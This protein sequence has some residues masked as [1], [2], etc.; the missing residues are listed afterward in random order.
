[1]WFLQLM[2]SEHI[3]NSITMAGNSAP[4][5]LKMLRCLRSPSSSLPLLKRACVTACKESRVQETS[6]LALAVHIHHTRFTMRSLTVGKQRTENTLGKLN[7]SQLNA[8]KYICL[9][10]DK[11]PSILLFILHT[12]TTEGWRHLSLSSFR[13]D[14]RT[15]VPKDLLSVGSRFQG[16]LRPAG[17]GT[18]SVQLCNPQEGLVSPLDIRVGTW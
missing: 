10:Y 3:A 4:N 12:R 7:P 15:Q 2:D 14:L 18:I 16:K 1:M 8:G 17:F 6:R 13:P 9:N 11:E 5:S